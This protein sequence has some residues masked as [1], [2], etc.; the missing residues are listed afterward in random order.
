MK[1]HI[2]T[3]GSPKLDYAKAGWQ[4]YLGRLQHYHQ[5][6]VTHIADKHNDADHLLQ[7]SRT[8]TAPYVV[9][10]TIDG[11]Q[12][13]SHQLA[14]FVDKRAQQAQELCFIIGGPDGLPQA[15]IDQANQE[16]GL[17]ALTFP[18]DLAMVVLAESLYRASTINSRHP[19]HR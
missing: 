9:A 19:Y 15:V 6:R 12:Q 2:I 13:T 4:E 1:I 11:P 16:L 5:I 18:H 3:V 10:L 8:S 17:S 14:A 7:A